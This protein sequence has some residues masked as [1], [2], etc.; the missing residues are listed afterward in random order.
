MTKF[1]AEF[2][3]FKF[4]T[5]NEQWND[6]KKCDVIQQLMPRTGAEGCAPG[7]QV[8]NGNCAEVGAPL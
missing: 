1:H 4:I 5:I 2:P 7:Y 6:R 8:S 3:N